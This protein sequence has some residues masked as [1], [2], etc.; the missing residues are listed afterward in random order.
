MSTDC[1]QQNTSLIYSRVT[2]RQPDKISVTKTT[3]D[4]KLIT[5]RLQ[6]RSKEQGGICVLYKRRLPFA[7]YS[8]D[9]GFQ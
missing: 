3:L 2:T 7:F 9:L 1:S 4:N 5:Q 8:R 6:T